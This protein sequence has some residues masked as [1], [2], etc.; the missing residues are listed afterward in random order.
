VLGEIENRLDAFCGLKERRRL[1]AFN[2][3]LSPSAATNSQRWFARYCM[4]SEELA[5]STIW[6]S[7]DDGWLGGSICLY[8]AERESEMSSD[9]GGAIGE[10]LTL[11]SDR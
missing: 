9:T 2:S 4:K 1:N 8:S 6:S 11:R 3:L 5:R 10:K 7:T